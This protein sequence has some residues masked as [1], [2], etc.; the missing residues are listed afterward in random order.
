M[1]WRRSLLRISSFNVRIRLLR[2]IRLLLII[3]MTL[4]AAIVLFFAVFPFC[5]LL[6]PLFLKHAFGLLVA[7]PTAE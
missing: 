7:T 4:L 5:S 3:I 6:F 2:P 1:R